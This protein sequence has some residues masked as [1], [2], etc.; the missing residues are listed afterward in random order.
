M[1]ISM[2]VPGGISLGFVSLPVYEPRLSML[3][4]ITSLGGIPQ[5]DGV[6]DVDPRQPIDPNLN[7]LKRKSISVIDTCESSWFVA[8][9]VSVAAIVIFFVAA[10]GT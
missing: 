8:S 7:N 2:A 10:L 9:T 3:R 6:P 4:L 1:A 5:G